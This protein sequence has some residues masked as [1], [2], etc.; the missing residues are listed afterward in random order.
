MLNKAIRPGALTVRALRDCAQRI[1]RV[2]K[3]FQLPEPESFGR[4]SF[5]KLEAYRNVWE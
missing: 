5:L 4:G 1:T 2:S 3:A